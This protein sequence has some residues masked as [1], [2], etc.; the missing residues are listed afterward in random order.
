MRATSALRASVF[1]LNAQNCACNNS[2]NEYDLNKV[3]VV[4]SSAR[5][6]FLG[7]GRTSEEDEKR[8][9]TS[10]GARRAAEKSSRSSLCWFPRRCLC[11][12]SAPARCTTRYRPQL[13]LGGLEVAKKKARKKV[14]KKAVA[15]KKGA[16][17]RRT[18]KAK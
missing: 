12:S 15:K 16:K 14:A 8:T 4:S 17:K 5:L 6:K 2:Q 10:G 11:R 3:G 1:A 9:T 13:L 7:N 18:K